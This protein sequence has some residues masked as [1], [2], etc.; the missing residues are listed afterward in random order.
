M[1]RKKYALNLGIKAATHENLVLSSVNFEPQSR[2]WLQHMAAASMKKS[3]AIG[4]VKYTHYNYFY[5][6]FDFLRT[7]KNY[8]LGK[9]GVYYSGTSAN[10]SYSK[11][12]FFSSNGFVQHMEIPFG[13]TTLFANNVAKKSNTTFCLH[14]DSFV[15]P[16]QKTNFKEWFLKQAKN[17]LKLRHCKP[18]ALIANAILFFKSFYILSFSAFFIVFQY[19][20]T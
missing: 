7:I 9:I 1:A 6:F 13:E 17:D 4:Y 14:K 3:M 8:T 18:S 20:R 10:V 2:S 5:R 19:S 15:A 12:L 16:V 11:E